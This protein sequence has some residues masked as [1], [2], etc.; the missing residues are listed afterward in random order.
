M[1]KKIIFL[2]LGISIGVAGTYFY[3]QQQ[4][5]KTDLRADLDLL[6]ENVVEI[7]KVSGDYVRVSVSPSASEG[8]GYYVLAKKVSNGHYM[9]II[10]SNAS[11]PPCSIVDEYSIPKDL[12]ETDCENI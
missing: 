5:V 4:S 12:F 9:N 10:R 2:I 1:N 7:E 3:Y 8:G 6:T 11:A